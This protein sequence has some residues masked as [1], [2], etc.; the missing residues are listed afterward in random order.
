MK[1]AECRFYVLGSSL[2]GLP[3]GSGICHGMPPIPQMI[4]VGNGVGVKMTSP[5]VSANRLACSLFERPPV[6]LFEE[7]QHADGC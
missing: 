4:Q 1:C 7:K 5:V 2:E 6:V 3:P